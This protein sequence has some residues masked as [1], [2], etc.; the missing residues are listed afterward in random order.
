MFVKLHDTQNLEQ[1]LNAGT[2]RIRSMNVILL[3]LLTLQP[4]TGFC[5]LHQV[6]P[7]FSIFDDVAQISQFIFFKSFTTSPLRL[8]FG[9]TYVFTPIGPCMLSAG[10]QCSVTKR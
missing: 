2:S 1:D 4:Y 7:G 8:F 3:H 10:L 9:R 6:I 5:P